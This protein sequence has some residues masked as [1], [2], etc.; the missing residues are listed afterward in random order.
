MH[1]KNEITVTEIVSSLC[2]LSC[3]KKKKIKK[4]LIASTYTRDLYGHFAKHISVHIVRSTYL[5]LNQKFKNLNFADFT[6][7]LKG[8]SC[9]L[10]VHETWIKTEYIPRKHNKIVKPE[11][12]LKPAPVNTK[13]FNLISRFSCKW[14][15]INLWT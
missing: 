10:N 15:F 2:P 3:N 11:L 8:T 14:C 6:G 9:T 1:V 5:V 4:K 7:W 12:R 13:F